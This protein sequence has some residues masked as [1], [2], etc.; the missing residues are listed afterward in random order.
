ML[1]AHMYKET[2]NR[3][4]EDDYEAGRE[5]TSLVALYIDSTDRCPKS[6]EEIVGE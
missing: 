6:I 1:V 4:F 3:R 5:F 2:Y